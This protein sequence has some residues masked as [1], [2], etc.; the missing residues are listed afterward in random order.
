[1]GPASPASGGPASGGPA[2]TPP[3][4][5]T[6]IGSPVSTTWLFA[7][8]PTTTA[9]ASAHFQTFATTPPPNP[10]CA[11]PRF[12]ASGGPTPNPLR[13][14]GGKGK[15]LSH[16]RGVC[17]FWVPRMATG[18]PFGSRADRGDGA[19]AAGLLARSVLHQRVLQG[20][21]A[22][23]GSA[24]IFIRSALG[25]R[26]DPL[27]HRTPPGDG[28]GNAGE[29]PASGVPHAGRRAR[30]A[31]AQATASRRRR[32]LE[33]DLPRAAARAARAGLRLRQRAHA[34]ECV[35]ARV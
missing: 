4:G 14:I 30:P 11:G 35:Q 19:R 13:D 15:R 17:Y 32:S 16:S 8:A 31:L 10:T 27:H 34:R 33:G 7:H 24:G 2:S 25:R 29:L 18:I 21:H 23:R 20:R 9:A 26:R 28:A 6:T 1:E 12:F 22:G 5:F 3:S